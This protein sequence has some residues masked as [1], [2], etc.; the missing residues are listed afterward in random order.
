MRVFSGYKAAQSEL[1]DP[2]IAIGIFDGVHIGHVRVI[3][4]MLGTKEHTADKVV[5]TFDPHPRVF[6]G[7]VKDAPRIMSLEHRLSIFRR[8]G[9]DAAIVVKFTRH[10]A[11]MSPE[12][13][14]R[15]V[16]KPLGTRLVYVGANFYFGKNKCGNADVFRAIGLENGIEVRVVPPV[17]KNGRI[18]SSTWLRKLISRGDLA[19]SGTLLRRPVSVL[20]TVVKGESIAKT[21]GIPTANI[22]PHHEVVPPP[23]VYAVK[24]DVEGVIRDGVL[25]IGFKP[26]FFGYKL[27]K[28]KEPFLEVH[29]MNFQGDLYGKNIEL[30]F[31]FLLR[32]EKKFRDIEELRRQIGE[33]ISAAKRLLVTPKTFKRIRRFSFTGTAGGLSPGKF[34]F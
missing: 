16:L 27:K 9:A 22:D 20:G 33:D 11:E 31:F 10:I 34:F 17:R 24:G 8:M 1:K 4:K 15:E 30:F 32:S 26:T 19:G 18:V 23:G 12:D 2:V 6:F 14:V 3:R 21:F 28:R 29:F 5:L 13:F 25:N 7:S